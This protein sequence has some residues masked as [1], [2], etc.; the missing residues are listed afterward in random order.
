MGRSKVETVVIV[1][2][3]AAEAE[4]YDNLMHLYFPRTD[5]EAI[6]GAAVLPES[7]WSDW[8]EVSVEE[9]KIR[10]SNQL[11]QDDEERDRSACLFSPTDDDDCSFLNAKDDADDSARR[12]LEGTMI[13]AD[14]TDKAAHACLRYL[15]RAREIRPEPESSRF[16]FRAGQD[17]YARGVV[18]LLGARFPALGVRDERTLPLFVKELELLQNERFVLMYM[19]SGVSS[20]DTANLEVLQEMLEV[21]SAK[22]RNSLDQLLV[23]HPELWFRAAFALG[24]AVSDNAATVWHNTVYLDSLQDLSAFI[25]LEQLRLPEYIRHADLGG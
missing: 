4:M 15:R 22:Y 23:L 7:C 19:N 5:Q 8:G 18:V 25:S 11:I 20:M 21:I 16:V 24:R 6:S 1:A 2:A 9:R 14:S 13:E 3:D 17:R 12:R 10:V